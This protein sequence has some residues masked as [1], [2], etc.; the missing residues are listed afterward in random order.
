MKLDHTVHC[1]TELNRQDQK[2]KLRRTAKASNFGP[3]G[4]FESFLAASVSSLDK[5]CTKNEQHQIHK[6]SVFLKRSIFLQ[7]S[8]GHLLEK[9][10]S[11]HKV[12]S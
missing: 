9:V 11:L 10:Q 7:F 3:R 5:L 8:V 1:F 4:N 12:Q 2:S 6:S